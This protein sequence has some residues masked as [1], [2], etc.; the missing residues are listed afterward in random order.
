[1]VRQKNKPEL[2]RLIQLG[3]NI[4]LSYSCLSNLSIYF[5]LVSWLKG[6]DLVRGQLA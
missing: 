2:T 1:M 4:A 6:L 3:T 5:T